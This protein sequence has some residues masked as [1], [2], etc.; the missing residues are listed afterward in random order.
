MRITITPTRDWVLIDGQPA[1]VWE[2]RS[3]GGVPCRVLVR[4]VQ[5]PEG[6]DPSEFDAALLECDPPAMRSLRGAPGAN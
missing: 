6:A 5:V 4:G 3:E 1:R 2:G